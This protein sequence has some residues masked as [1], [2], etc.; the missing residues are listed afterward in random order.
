MVYRYVL[1]DLKIAFDSTNLWLTLRFSAF[2]L[3]GIE[4]L[5]L[6]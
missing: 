5:V 3:F 1:I 2:T 4:R 6:D